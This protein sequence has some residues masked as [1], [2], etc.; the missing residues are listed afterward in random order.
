M[1][2]ATSEISHISELLS[3][4]LAGKQLMAVSGSIKD[5]LWTLNKLPEHIWSVSP[6]LHKQEGT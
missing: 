5:C 1:Y 2:C 3:Y 4:C 6:G